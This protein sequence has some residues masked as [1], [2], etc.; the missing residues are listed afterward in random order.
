[1]DRREFLKHMAWASLALSLPPARGNSSSDDA[2]FWVFI[3]ANG[4]W[5]PNLFCDPHADDATLSPFTSDQLR[6]T[7]TTGL[8]YAPKEVATNGT[9][10][11][12]TPAT[13]T[14]VTSSKPTKTNSWFSTD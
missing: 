1:M 12:P 4:A 14:A 10:T 7:S 6:T 5:D 13:T 8:K 3:D 9:T 11:P 2:L